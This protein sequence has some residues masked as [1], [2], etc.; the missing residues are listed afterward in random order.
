MSIDQ[1]W[2]N[3]CIAWKVKSWSAL[4]ASWCWR[5]L[6][7]H[8]NTVGESNTIGS[9][10]TQEWSISTNETNISSGRVAG[11][12]AWIVNSD[13]ASLV[14]SKVPETGVAQNTSKTIIGNFCF[15][16]IVNLT[17][18]DWSELHTQS[19]W[20]IY[21]SKWL[22]L[23]SSEYLNIV[24]VTNS[25]R[26]CVRIWSRICWR[27]LKLSTIQRSREWITIIN[28]ICESHQWETIGALNA[29]S[30]LTL[31]IVDTITK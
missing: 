8:E 29:L 15:I 19:L 14:G 20:L 5:I 24:C 25:A 17:I 6:V 7:A 11:T 1:S 21:E 23:S 13:E 31:L 22:P 18:V 30:D 26:D 16:L 9:I 27:W 2:L 4:S 28:V 10:G 3:A 12:L